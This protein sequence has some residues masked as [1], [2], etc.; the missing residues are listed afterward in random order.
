MNEAAERDILALW[1]SG[2]KVS[3][4][5]KKSGYSLGTIKKL[6]REKGLTGKRLN[7]QLENHMHAYEMRQNGAKWG[8]VAKALGYKNGDVAQ[9]CAR[10]YEKRIAEAREME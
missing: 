3:D 2:M 10:K 4:V 7:K 1:E 8:D 6:I 9:Q 5:V